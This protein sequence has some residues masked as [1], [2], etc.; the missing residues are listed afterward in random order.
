MAT[1]I[2]PHG[3]PPLPEPPPPAGLY[4]PVVIWEG[5][6]YVSGQ[7]PFSNGRLVHPGAVGRDVTEEQAGEAAELAALNVLAQI[8]RALGSLDRVRTLLRVDG[9][10]ASAPGW[11]GQPRVLDRASAVFRRVLGERGRHAR[12]AVGVAE[13]PVNAC[14]ELVVTFAVAEPPG[15]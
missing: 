4:D 12:S 11:T 3:A 5:V 10:V 14:V 7:L 15:A 6:G 13:L 2:E 1:S 8:R 9:I